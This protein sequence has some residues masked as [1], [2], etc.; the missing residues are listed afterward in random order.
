MDA[1]ILDQV[2]SA[3]VGNVKMFITNITV[4][5]SEEFTISNIP[6]IPKAIIGSKDSEEATLS[7]LFIKPMTQTYIMQVT[8]W[9]TNFIKMITTTGY[10]SGLWYFLIIG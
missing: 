7:P 3:T 6:F 9:G 5:T 1:K 4:K 2:S 8:S 10:H